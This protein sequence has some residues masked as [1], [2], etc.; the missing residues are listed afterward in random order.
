MLILKSYI[1]QAV[2]IGLCSLLLSF[3]FAAAQSGRTE[4]SFPTPPQTIEALQS[5]ILAM[6]AETTLSPEQKTAIEA[7]Y[8]SAVNELN[9]ANQ[10]RQDAVRF[11]RELREAETTESRLQRDIDGL[12]QSLQNQTDQ[13]D[14]DRSL[15][16][17]E[18]ELSSR[19]SDLRAYR[20]ELAQY[21]TTLDNLLQRPLQ[22]REDL[23]LI[24]NDGTDFET[25]LTT[26]GEGQE[27]LAEK[28]A[29]RLLE[30]KFHRNQ[31]QTIAL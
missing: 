28:A 30:A 16:L 4:I 24:R 15:T 1:Y 14:L 8:N 17:L 18:R 25:E 11:E 26:L 21:E 3:S 9:L 5:E 22:L 12:R 6:Q 27:T 7:T 23:A 19:E 13:T 20:T 31:T 29:R 2:L 10:A